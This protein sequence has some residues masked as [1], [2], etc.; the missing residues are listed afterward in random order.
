MKDMITKP[1]QAE[2]QAE[3]VR[4][5]EDEVEQN[6]REVMHEAAMHFNLAK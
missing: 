3:N 4:P 5:I 6:R 2:Y 1:M